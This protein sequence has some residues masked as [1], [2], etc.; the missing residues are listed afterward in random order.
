MRADKRKFNGAK[1]LYGVFSLIVFFIFIFQVG[2]V[3]ASTEFNKGLET[4]GKAS[5]A[6]KE[7]A[8]KNPGLFLAKMT[9]TIL[10]PFFM[11]VIAM[12]ILSYGGYTWMMA[13]GDEQKV[14]KAKTIITN[15]II[16]VIIVF[17]AYAIV[18]LIIPLWIF[19]TE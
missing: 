12:L 8:A 5:G 10:A 9:G 19:V 18:T 2:S 6:Y 4:T 11:G 3:L 15:T 16:A 17:S 13:R 1:R 14:E 7:E